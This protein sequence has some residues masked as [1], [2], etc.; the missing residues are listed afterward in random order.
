MKSYLYSF[1]AL[2]LASVV[3]A[4]VPNENIA[5]QIIAARQKNTAM[6]KQYSWTCR[7][8]IIHE[9]EV[10]DTRVEQVCYGPDGTLQRSLVS[11]QGPHMPGGLLRHA[12]A[13]HKK[14]ETEKYLKGLRDL[15]EQYTMSSAGAVINFIA[16]AKITPVQTPDGK[17]VLTMT[18]NNV[19]NPGDTLTMTIDPGTFHMT[20]V[21]I[22]STYD[23]H[24][25][26]ANCS[27]K[28]LASGLTF[29]QFATV[30]VPD[31]NLGLQIHNFDYVQ[32]N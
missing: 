30:Q 22:S 4:Q 15:L 8:E 14:E 12:A 23:G 3:T 11:N 1:V 18:G 10:K 24:S 25:V 6:M 2:L 20:G 26:T 27:F 32:N 16:G 28:T 13:E 7:T 9:G 17:T 5:N 19:V 31:K 29:M 21:S